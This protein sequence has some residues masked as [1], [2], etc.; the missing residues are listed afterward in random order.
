MLETWKY[1]AKCGFHCSEWKR[2]I[3]NINTINVVYYSNR[4]DS[5]PCFTLFAAAFKAIHS[6]LK[7]NAT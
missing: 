3:S 2:Q 4:V 1:G 7:H 6:K 5:L